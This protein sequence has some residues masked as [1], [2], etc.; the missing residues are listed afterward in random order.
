MQRLSACFLFFSLRVFTLCDDVL[1]LLELSC[2]RRRIYKLYLSQ[3]NDFNYGCSSF[4]YL[5]HN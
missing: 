4:S 1:L 3:G 5:N 2:L